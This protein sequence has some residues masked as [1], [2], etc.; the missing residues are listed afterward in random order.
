MKDTVQF[1]KAE[2]EELKKR[3]EDVFDELTEA[4]KRGSHCEAS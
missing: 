1:L 4:I 2:N 3:V